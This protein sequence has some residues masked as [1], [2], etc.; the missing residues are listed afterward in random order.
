MTTI[1][2][3][4]LAASSAVGASALLGFRPIV[5]AYCLP[6]VVGGCWALS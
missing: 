3:V 2:L 6:F 4:P 1:I 5:A